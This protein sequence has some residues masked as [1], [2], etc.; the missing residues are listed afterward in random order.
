MARFDE[1]Y[2][3][4][5]SSEAIILAAAP[6]HHRLLWIHPFGDG[7]GRVARLMSD[8]M[9]SRTLR[10]YSLWSVSRGLANAEVQ[11]KRLLAACDQERQ[12][13]L[14]GRGSL[15]EKA[16][17]E[18]SAF[19]LTICLEQVHFMRKVMRLDEIGSHID[20]WVETASAYGEPAGHRLHPAAGEILKAVLHDGALSVAN[21][22]TLVGSGVDAIEIVEQLKHHGVVSVRGDAVS[23]TLPAHRAERFLP[24]LFP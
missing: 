11:Y 6:A 5:T 18:F 9:L 7:N 4:L 20:R 2:G 16:L 10:T 3:R 21:C 12:G 8:A 15:S 19:F 14:D 22:R 24:G 13:D 23:F 1:V 17:T